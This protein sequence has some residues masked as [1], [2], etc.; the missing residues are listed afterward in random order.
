MRKATQPGIPRWGA[1]RVNKFKKLLSA[2]S[3]S[4]FAAC[5]RR[6]IKQC[7]LPTGRNYVWIVTQSVQGNSQPAPED[8]PIGMLGE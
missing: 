3:L 1:E 4:L 5:E 7:L 8:F 2:F 6:R